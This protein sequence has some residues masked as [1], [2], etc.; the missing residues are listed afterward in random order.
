MTAPLTPLLEALN[1]VMAEV[2]YVQKGKKNAFHNYKY[3]GEED[4][5][6]V[7]RPA[8]VKN[9]IILMPS[10]ATAPVLDEHGNTHLTV[11]YTLAHK[12]GAV[13]PEKLVVPGCGNDKNSKGGIG[14]KGPYKALT[15][16][17]K[18]LLFKLFQIATGDDPEVASDHDKM[19]ADKPVA[20]PPPPPVEPVNQALGLTA[21]QR[22][23]AAEEWA[24]QVVDLFRDSSPDEINA[25]H[26]NTRNRGALS[27]L[28]KNHPDLHER[29]LQAMNAERRAA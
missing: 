19:G 13:W 26:A 1:A 15:G 24:N 14:D 29:I 5:L 8:L 18:Y 17:N 12:S 10:L 9:G 4:L 28:E 2:G 22:R 7:L 11:S 16:A 21:D 27:K 6:E 20:V 23:E 25:W 3:A